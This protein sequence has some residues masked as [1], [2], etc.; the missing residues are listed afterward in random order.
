[1]GK[2]EM[3]CGL[4]NNNL[5]TYLGSGFQKTEVTWE[6]SFKKNQYNLGDDV[7]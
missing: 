2:R 3:V 5:L 4:T 1:M 7:I 6:A